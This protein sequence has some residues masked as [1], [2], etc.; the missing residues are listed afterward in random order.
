MMRV[1]FNAV[2]MLINNSCYHFLIFNN[3]YI[4]FIMVYSI[5]VM[6]LLNM[7]NNIIRY[8]KRSFRY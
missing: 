3:Y 6:T 1:V 4:R 7:L 5:E 2:S 8:V